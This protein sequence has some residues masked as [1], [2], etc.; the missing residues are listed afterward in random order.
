MTPPL[1]ELVV[2]S[3]AIR[4][5]KKPATEPPMQPHLFA[6]DQVMQSAIGTTAE[7]RITPMNVCRRPSAL[8][9][10]RASKTAYVKPT[11]RDANIKEDEPCKAHA[12]CKEGNL[13]NAIQTRKHAM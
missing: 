13:G 3:H 4:P 9:W 12:N 8:F 6:R 7:P 10:W 1:S 2:T 11:H 5:A